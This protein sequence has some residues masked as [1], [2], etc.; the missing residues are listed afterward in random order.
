[1]GPS[2]KPDRGN[3]RHPTC[4]SVHRPSWKVGSPT[5]SFMLSAMYPST[6]DAV[7]TGSRSRRV[8][9]V[10]CYELGRQP[11]HVATAA[12]FLRAAD[13]E[14]RA[15]DLAV[16][17]FDSGL[18]GW[19]D[20]VAIAVPMH[21]AMRLAARVVDTVR[22]LNPAHT[23]VLFGLYAP[24]CAGSL[25]PGSVDHAVGGEFEEEL[26]R[27]ADGRPSGRGIVLDRL[28]FPLPSRD[29]L[30]PL[31]RYARLMIDGEARLAAAV[32]LTRGCV[33]QCRHC[34]VPAVY[35]GR[36]RVVQQETLL[37]D[38]DQLVAM[39]AMHLTFADPDFLNSAPYA[40]RAVRSLHQRHPSLTFDVTTKVEH[41][42]EHRALLPELRQL[43]LL[44]VTTAAESTSEVVLRVLEKGHTH[45]QTIAAVRLLREHGI[46]PR[47]SLLPF[48][49]WTT[50]RDYLD[51]LD[52]IRDEDLLGS[53]DPV[54]LSIRL[55]LPP[56]S[57]LLDRDE[58]RPHLRAYEPE[59]F[60][61]RWEHPDARMDALQGELAAL[62][63]ARTDAGDE[64]HAVHAA[65]RARAVEAATAAAVRW[66]AGR[67]PLPAP[68][69]ELPRL[70]ESWF[71]CAE[72]TDLQ[73]A[74]SG[75]QPV[76]AARAV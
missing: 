23:I 53:V 50:L 9:I 56:G 2:R 74:R 66:A 70:S 45:A 63:A 13:H 17:D 52:F 3:Q 75:L 55:L 60:S 19:A 67:E 16:D 7:Q 43:G 49:P 38:V 41:I 8:L 57:L 22:V 68:G 34:P 36:L 61:H 20:M 15:L 35:G 27:I 29:L 54:Q 1:M 69:R 10:S 6:T 71:C 73:H 26:V 47:P 48:T 12:G 51:L 4:W 72:P 65:V 76:V 44:F 14:V 11:L 46:E 40:M 62:I 33:H 42:L 64:A 24:L 25:T 18:V 31:S 37:A 30:P 28:R 5:S 21:T 59:S 58:L 32:E 39:G